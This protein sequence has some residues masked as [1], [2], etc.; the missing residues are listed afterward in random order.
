MRKKSKLSDARPGEG[1][2]VNFSWPLFE[3]GFS[4]HEILT[5]GHSTYG[6]RGLSLEDV[7]NERLWWKNATSPNSIGNQVNQI[8]AKKHASKQSGK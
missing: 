6:W 8:I 4:D 3:R 2:L 1:E 7:S 5:K